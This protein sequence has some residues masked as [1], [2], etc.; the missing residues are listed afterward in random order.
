M[1]GMGEG[2]LFVVTVAAV[3]VVDS[4]C[5]VEDVIAGTALDAISVAGF[6]FDDD[7]AGDSVVQTPPVLVV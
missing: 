7:R 1:G 4:G 6:G 2:V 5:A 3:E